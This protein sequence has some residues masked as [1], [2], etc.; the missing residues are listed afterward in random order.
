MLA[1]VGSTR[2]TA[3]TPATKPTSM[4]GASASCWRTRWVTTTSYVATVPARPRPHPTRRPRS[5]HPDGCAQPERATRQAAR[6]RAWAARSVSAFPHSCRQHT[7]ASGLVHR[8]PACLLRH[9]LPAGVACQQHLVAGET[10]LTMVSVALPPGQGCF[11][12]RDQPW[13]RMDGRHPPAGRAAAGRAPARRCPGIA[14]LQRNARCRHIAWACHGLDAEDDFAVLGVAH[15]G[16]RAV[17]L[18][19][20]RPSS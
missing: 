8:D 2:R 15:N 13:E 1:W 12:P 18:S 19:W 10:V 7:R 14:Q 6:L 17:E 11:P 9:C 20:F 5:D 4:D 16:R 3:V